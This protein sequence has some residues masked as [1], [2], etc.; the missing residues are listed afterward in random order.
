M[1]YAE[2]TVVS[3][4]KS[5]IE[6]ERI[7]SR[8]HADQFATAID[9]D[10]HRA[11]IRFRCQGRVI[12]FEMELP[13]QSEQ[14]LRTRWRALCLTIKAKLES[15]ESKIETFEEAFLAHVVMPDGRTVGDVA[16]PEINRA[17]ENGQMPRGLLEFH[18]ADS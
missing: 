15:V 9:N 4:E 18:N 17:I 16:I 3:V 13:Q 5:R 2:K 12:R 7:L 8:Y 14:R 11:M 1:R 10:A 6:I